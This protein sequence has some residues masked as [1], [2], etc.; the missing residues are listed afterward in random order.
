MPGRRAPAIGAKPGGDRD[1]LRA[2]IR[3][4]RREQHADHAAEAGAHPRDRRR[5]AAPVEPRGNQVRQTG[6]RNRF[7]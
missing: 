1:E 3:M 2:A 5:A 4:P 6:D 7:V